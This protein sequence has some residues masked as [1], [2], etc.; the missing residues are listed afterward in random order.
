MLHQMFT[1]TLL[2]NCQVRL[3]EKFSEKIKNKRLSI[4]ELRVPTGS[5]NLYYSYGMRYWARVLNSKPYYKSDT[6][7]E[8]QKNFDI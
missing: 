5:H 4:G 1:N 6:T 2:L 3:I 8:R 7:D